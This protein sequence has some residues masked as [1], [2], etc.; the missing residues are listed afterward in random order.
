MCSAAPPPGSAPGTSNPAGT[1]QFSN[2]TADLFGANSY[3]R[4]EGH[5]PAAAGFNPDG[6]RAGYTFDQQA[7][8]RGQMP[9]STVTGQTM[10]MQAGGLAMPKPMDTNG[11]LL[12]PGSILPPA[13]PNPELAQAPKAAEVP[14]MTLPPA[15]SMPDA[16]FWAPYN[17]QISSPWSARQPPTAP[18]AAGAAGV[19]NALMRQ[20]SRF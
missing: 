16:S 11:M 4:Q 19:A 10:P 20:R 15:S 8:D 12:P 9:A 5:A 13:P 2:P 14:G 18:P 1:S 17:P 6:S 3:T 7:Q